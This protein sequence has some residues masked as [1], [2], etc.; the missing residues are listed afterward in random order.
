MKIRQN[1]TRKHFDDY[2]YCNT[3]AHDF[4]SKG[5]KTVSAMLGKNKSSVMMVAKDFSAQTPKLDRPTT[6]NNP[7]KGNNQDADYCIIVHG[8]NKRQGGKSKG[9][10]VSSV[11]I[12]VIAKHRNQE[13][14]SQSDKRFPFRSY[15]HP[16]IPTNTMNTGV[17]NG[18]G[19]SGP[20]QY[21]PPQQAQQMSRT[22]N[23]SYFGGG[24]ANFRT[25]M[26]HC[27]IEPFP[28]LNEGPGKHCGTEPVSNRGVGGNQCGPGGGGH[29]GT[30]NN[31][32]PSHQQ[33][34][35]HCSPCPMTNTA[36]PNCCKRHNNRAFVKKP[37]K[38]KSEH[39][40]KVKKDN[41][42]INNK[43]ASN[44]SHKSQKVKSEKFKDEDN[45]FPD[46]FV[47]DRDES[48]SVIE[49]DLGDENGEPDEVF[50]EEVAGDAASSLHGSTLHDPS[51]IQSSLHGGSTL[52]DPSLHDPSQ[53]DPSLQS[54]LHDPS[55]HDPS[56][57]DPSLQSTLH[58]ASTI[59]SSLHGPPSTVTAGGN[60][61]EQDLYN[62]L[63]ASTIGTEGP[64]VEEP[65]DDDQEG[66]VRGAA[67]D[68]TIFTNQS[69][70]GPY[71][72]EAN[73]QVSEIPFSNQTVASQSGFLTEQGNPTEGVNNSG[74]FSEAGNPSEQVNGGFLAE[75]GNFFAED[76]NSSRRFYS[77]T[78]PSNGTGVGGGGEQEWDKHDEA[79][80]TKKSSKKGLPPHQ[81]KPKPT[82][83]Y[84]PYK[85]P[86]KFK[87]I[88]HKQP[89]EC[90]RNQL[91]DL[92]ACHPFKRPYPPQ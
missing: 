80:N 10:C 52:Y 63:T 28:R 61:T 13:K 14:G 85:S 44:T 17:N 4:C 88:V 83:P 76:V 30:S 36:P 58:G 27:G 34:P 60:V 22:P 2:D 31:G 54:T 33:P 79:T 65:P 70:A 92:P 48:A 15:S 51:T 57:H 18:C 5:I 74:Y 73:T 59:Q 40:T 35:A 90:A 16:C 32:C 68:G 43:A 6:P 1:P 9:M 7:S 46:N 41:T 89:S 11:S 47:G 20:R 67:T 81:R 77:E 78:V 56:L 23:K 87:P 55:L 19:T 45:Q 38:N 66:T 26:N 91:D 21:T 29:F 72:S 37:H 62:A 82:K 71:G 3:L 25:G 12:F 53:H 75:E 42:N 84:K 50:I 8:K 24:G 39:A 64:I 49:E 69:G 86:F